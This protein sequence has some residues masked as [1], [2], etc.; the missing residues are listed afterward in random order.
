[1]NR[2]LTPRWLRRPLVV[3]SLA[4]LPALACTDTLLNVTDPDIVLEI[5]R[6]HV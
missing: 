5:G 6:A 3:A 4:A 2:Y 1:M